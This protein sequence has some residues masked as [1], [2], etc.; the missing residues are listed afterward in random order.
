ML[1]VSARLQ[2]PHLFLLYSHI[3]DKFVHKNGFMVGAGMTFCEFLAFEFELLAFTLKALRLTLK[4][5]DVS[6]SMMMVIATS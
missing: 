3:H 6:D 4:G 2:I 5:L 1:P